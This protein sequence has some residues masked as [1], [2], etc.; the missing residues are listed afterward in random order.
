MKPVSFV[1]G[2]QWLLEGGQGIGTVVLTA[3]I[4]REMKYDLEG[5]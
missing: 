1:P 3:S 4:F 5:P 2:E